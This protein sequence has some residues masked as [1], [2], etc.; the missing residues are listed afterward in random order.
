MTFAAERA[1]QLAM[2]FVLDNDGELMAAYTQMDAMMKN[3]ATAINLSPTPPI[4]VKDTPPK[5]H[6]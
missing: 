2:S 6:P 3:M 4:V 1:V 5:G